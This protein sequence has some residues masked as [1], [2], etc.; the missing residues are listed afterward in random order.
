MIPADGRGPAPSAP[1]TVLDRPWLRLAG[2]A[3]FL[4][5]SLRV[6]HGETF[7]ALSVPLGGSD[8]LAA[9]AERTSPVV[10]ALAVVRLAALAAA[11]YLTA[12]T[13]LTA[14]AAV[15]RWRP[16][17]AMAVRVSP[18]I[19]RRLVCRSAS[20]GL[21]V[22]ALLAVVPVSPRLA[23][24]P[25]VADVTSTASTDHDRSLPTSDD[26]LP[27]VGSP[28]TAR[29]TRE[30]QRPLADA[31]G[32]VVE[33]GDSFWSIAEETLAADGPVEPRDVARYC[34]RLIE[35]NRD[36]LVDRHNP[37]LLAVGQEL[38]IPPA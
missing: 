5:L 23:A 36:R 24:S 28:P 10:M 20:A 32:W 2:W 18:E 16:L 8:E 25:V 12:A 35:A 26:T 19:V 34:D 21:A 29:M 31:E 33:A 38:S 15:T 6:L 13:I 3:A 14:V 4:V 27:T 22:G 17:A 37:D 30:P 7:G 9:W 1:A 11:W